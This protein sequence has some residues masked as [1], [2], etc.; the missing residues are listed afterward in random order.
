M[1][2]GPKRGRPLPKVLSIAEVDRL[3]QTARQAAD[4][5]ETTASKRLRA[6]RLTC[7]L[8][9]VYATGLRVSELVSL[10]LTAARRDVRMLYIRGKGGKERLVPLNGAAKQAMA[11]YLAIRADA[12]GKASKWLFPSFGESGHITRQHFARELKILAASCGIDQRS[13]STSYH[14][15]TIRCRTY[16]C[17]RPM[18]TV[19]YVFH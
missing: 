15:D 4:D 2:G 10:P 11:A 14:P 19:C 13:N 18:G 16:M 12:G 17:I 5:P 6:A 3:M 9:A 7:L 1:V 8:E